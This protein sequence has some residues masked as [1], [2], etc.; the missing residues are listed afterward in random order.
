MKSQ[1]RRVAFVLLYALMFGIIGARADILPIPLPD[2]EVDSNPYRFNGLIVANA[3]SLGSGA[4]IA[5]VLSTIAR[6]PACDYSDSHERG[7][8][9]DSGNL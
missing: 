1:F 9:S 5:G 3:E 4:V 8:H 2:S 7:N 6:S